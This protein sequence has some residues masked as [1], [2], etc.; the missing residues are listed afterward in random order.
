M[1]NNPSHQELARRLADLYS[2]FAQVQAVAMGGSLASG[3]TTDGASDIDLYVFT[4]V[5]IPLDARVEIVEQVGGASKANMNLDYWDLGDE[6]FDAQTGIE[7]DVMYWDTRW[8]E[9][10][11]ARVLRDHQASVGYSTAH[12]NT[13]TQAQVLFDRA[14]W[15]ARLQESSR[16]PY[17]EEL[18]H[19]I[20]SRNLALLRD[21]I[22]GYLHQIEKAVQR[23]D[24]VSVNHRVAALLA[25][26]FDVV[27]AY[28][29]VLHPGEK[30]MVVQA[31]RL[32]AHL[33]ANMERQVLRVLE[34]SGTTNP[35]LVG[36]VNH[37]IDG[38]E[39]MLNSAN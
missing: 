25:S 8:I 16:Q 34:L 36:A 27:F 30:R 14:G 35:E 12:W 22:P 4:T 13:I 24:P 11:L 5:L 26:Y 7:V 23:N 39:E 33:P 38:L 37:L 31:Q 15:F 19:A 9:E 6:W 17:P 28:N 29:R 10:T 3:V 20:I 32:C 2:Q 18:R 21:L 1:N